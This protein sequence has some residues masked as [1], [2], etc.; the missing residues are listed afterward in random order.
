[1]QFWLAKEDGLL[2][3]LPVARRSTLCLLQEARVVTIRGNVSRGDRPHIN[4]E[5]VRYDSRALSGIAGLIGQQLR[6][7]FN[8][9]D[10]RHLHAFHMDGS[11]LGVLT[12]ARPWCFTPH[13]LRVRQEIFSLIHQR[14][15]AVREGSDPVGVW[16]AYKKEQARSHTRDANDLARMLTDRARSNQGSP[17]PDVTDAAA[18]VTSETPVVGIPAKTTSSPPWLTRIFTFG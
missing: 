11:E 6:I 14:K 2:R 16:F 1:M 17:A 3:T 13:S 10:I 12:A 15:L 9:K 4:F 5:H 18:A 7:Y 8:V